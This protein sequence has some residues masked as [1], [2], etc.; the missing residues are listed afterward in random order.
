M[1]VVNSIEILE[2]A[3]IEVLRNECLR[4]KL[5]T[6]LIGDALVRESK[7]ELSCEDTVKRI[8][9]ILNENQ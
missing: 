2:C 4:L 7:W 6:N 9:D 3:D 5:I 8:R 1:I